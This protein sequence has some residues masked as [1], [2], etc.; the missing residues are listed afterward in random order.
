MKKIFAAGI[1]V[2]LTLSL[3]AVYFQALPITNQPLK[4]NK[5]LV[6]G[7]INLVRTDNFVKDY[8]MGIFSACFILDP[9]AR[10]DASG[11]VIPY[12][13]NWSTNDSRVWRL[14][15]IANAKWHDGKPVTAEDIAFTIMYL[16]EKDPNYAVHFQFVNSAVALDNRTVEVTLTKEWT[17]F[18]VGLAA[19]R[20]IPKHVWFNVTD[21]SAYTG[22]NRNIG[23]GPFIYQ[24]F[25][26]ASG[27][28]TFIANKDYWKGKPNVDKV[29]LKFYTTTDAMLMAL[30]KGE[31][32]TTYAYAKGI[33]PIYVPSLLGDKNITIMVY[34]NFG[35]DNSLWFNCKR[36]PYNITEFRI[37]I[38]YALDYGDYLN[39]IAAGY[40]EIPTRGWIPNCWDYYVI[41]P[42]LSKNSS[43][44]EQ[45]LSSLG[46]FDRNGDGWRDYPN[47]T[48]M[49]MKIIARSDIAESLRLAE[50]VKRD[51]EK[52]G[53]RV[54]ITPVDVSTFQTLTQRTK[55]FD[56]AI[57]RT[58]FWGMMMY[59]GA[60]TLYFDH[61]NMGWANVDD[62]EYIAIVDEILRTANQ[63]RVKQLY[64]RIQDLYAERMYVIPL[65]WGKIIQPYR[66]DLVEGISYEPMYGIL[67]RD[68][69]YSIK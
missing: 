58:T 22:N 19:T 36:Y 27:T 35:V 56:A 38:S 9:L 11:K 8:Y 20:L 39:Y 51:L 29:I 53:I 34:P 3:A 31:I 17:A 13:V 6:I 28:M 66:S 7:T 37:A 47:G 1:L 18:I 12:L 30:K 48:S 63:T 49:I 61:R 16:K 55:D 5:T 10:I 32:A 68:T 60:G 4:Q 24:G 64:E 46:F 2:V 69:W 59:A 54:Q 15:L 62:P 42:K 26:S 25:D 41:K 65:Y 14:N 23:C 33:D 67:G 57:S 50:L 45:L 40:G 21:P 44:A 43:Y 52:I